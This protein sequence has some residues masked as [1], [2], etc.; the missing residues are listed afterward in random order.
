MSTSGGHGT[1]GGMPPA[2]TGGMPATGGGASTTGANAATGGFAAPTGGAMSAS[3][4][5]RVNVGGAVPIGGGIN[6]GGVAPTGGRIGV[7]GAVPTGGGINTGGV[8]PTGGRTSVGGT[9][10]TGGALSTGGL[11]AIGGST[12]GVTATG[13]SSNAGGSTS[14]AGDPLTAFCQ[15]DKSKILYQGNKEVLAPATSYESALAMDCCMAWG[16]NLHSKDALGFDLDIETIW[17]AVSSIAP[18]VFTVGTSMQ[19]MRAVVRRSM[20]SPSSSGVPAEGTGE[21]LSAFSFQSSFD[22]ALCLSLYNTETTLWKTLIYVPKVTIATYTSRPRF[23]FFLLGDSTITPAQASAQGLDSVTLAPNPL[24][25]LGKIAYVSSS[26]NEIGFNPG[27]K[28]GD[29][30]QTQLKSISIAVPFVMLADGARISLGAFVSNVSSAISSVLNVTIEDIQSD[31]MVLEP[32][33]AAPNPLKDPR[34]VTALSETGKLI[35]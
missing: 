11:A 6:T 9:A 26:T 7:G 31:S 17:P 13:G 15:G 5:G 28:V 3:T 20:E 33:G 21:L 18:G 23:Q 34:A 19:P 16:V 30:L 1:A 22:L 12:G 10:P 24:L 29:S 2:T 35:P 4:G 8:A 32:V 25:D 27:Q 14:D